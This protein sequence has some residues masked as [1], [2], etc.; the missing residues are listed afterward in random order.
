MAES[1]L[2]L[3]GT[4]SNGGASQ[5]EPCK[6]GEWQED[7]GS[8]QCRL[9][10]PGYHA[11]APGAFEQ[12]SCGFGTYSVGGA[13]ECADCLGS[14]QNGEYSNKEAQSLCNRCASP[15]T[16]LGDAST[17]CDACS[18]GYYWHT[19]YWETVG[20]PAWELSETQCLD[21]CKRCEDQGDDASMTCAEPGIALENLPLKADYWR[22]SEHAE[23]VYE[24]DLDG[25]CVGGADWAEYCA[26]GHK[27]VLCGVCEHG[28]YKDT[29]LLKCVECRDNFDVV[30]SAGTIIGLSGGLF[31][32][33]AI[34][35]FVI[36]K[37]FGL[38]IREGWAFVSKL[39]S[40]KASSALE[41]S[42]A[43]VENTAESDTNADFYKSLMIKLKIIIALYQIAGQ[44]RRE[45]KKRHIFFFNSGFYFRFFSVL[46]L[47]LS[48]G[49]LVGT[50]DFGT[51]REARRRRLSLSLSLVCG[52]RRAYRRA[53][54]LSSYEA[55][56]LSARDTT[57]LRKTKPLSL[58]LSLSLSLLDC[59]ALGTQARWRSLCLKL[60]FPR[61]L[62][63][64]SSSRPSSIWTSC[65]LRTKTASQISIISTN[66]HS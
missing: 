9:A 61:Y 66:S 42:V 14:A 52:A 12:T 37:N 34:C 63:S 49:R 60:N 55:F 31:V 11:P 24:C 19:Y 30:G 41:H 54:G 59:L 48:L 44:P 28:F 32:V 39:G 47:S 20:K 4:Y 64:V 26:P 58:S 57:N 27:G 8:T 53:S 38:V 23:E 21:C 2:C 1:T 22:V 43:V 40:D 15:L 45:K 5:C 13:R 65:A 51:T 6:P 16:T 29:V 33:G 7:S 17:F 3:P 35:A 25:A 46:S 56:F 50:R 36:Y 18:E 10:E 62:I